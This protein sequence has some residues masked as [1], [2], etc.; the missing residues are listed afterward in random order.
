MPSFADRIG[1]GV[2]RLTADDEPDWLEFQARSHGAGTRQADPAWLA[3]LRANPD[4][5]GAGPRIWICRRDGEVVGSQSGVPFRLKEGSRTVPAQWAIDLFVEPAWRLRGVGPALI[6][7]QLRSGGLVAGQGI[8]D[9]AH[10]AYTRGGWND[11]GDIPFYARPVN[12]AWI[13][14]QLGL[15]G[16]RATTARLALGP[17]LAATRWASRVMARAVQSRLEPIAAFD[18]RAD[19]VWADAAPAFDV[20]AVRDRRA[21]A[22][23]FDAIPGADSIARHYL[24]ERDR[25]RGYVV[26]RVESWGGTPVLAIVDYLASPAWLVPLLGGVLGLDTTRNVEAIQCRTLN[27]AGDRVFRATGFV[28]VSSSDPPAFLTRRARTPRR[29]MINGGGTPQRPAFERARWFV[30]GADSDGSWTFERSPT[31]A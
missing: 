4:L 5:D 14:R 6:E 19:D 27:A 2:G 9:A 22:W 7:A 15:T 16:R 30:T 18:E 23:R 20:I 1:A 26:T 21:L 12:A 25:V 29:F 10:R 8:S 11:L 28:R 24:M 17:A 3:W 31:P 13:P